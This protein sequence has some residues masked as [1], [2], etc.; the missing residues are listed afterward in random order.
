MDEDVNRANLSQN[1]SNV[2][3]S[4]ELEEFASE[5]SLAFSGC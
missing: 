4:N 5:E 2:I 1:P 3:L